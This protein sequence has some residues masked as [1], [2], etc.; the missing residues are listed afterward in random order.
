MTK[1][2]QLRVEKLPKEKRNA[3]MFA[4]NSCKREG[5]VPTVEAFEYSLQ[6]AEGLITHEEALAKII[7]LHKKSKCKQN[8]EKA[9]RH[10]G[11]INITKFFGHY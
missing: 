2:Q 4:Y 1:E 7:A 9:E 6:A 3:L 11:F 10:L 8:K 5:R